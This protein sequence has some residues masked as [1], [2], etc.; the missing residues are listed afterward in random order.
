MLAPE[1]SGATDLDVSPDL[2]ELRLPVRIFISPVA[3]DGSFPGLQR[4]L[5]LTTVH[6]LGH[7]L[8]IFAHSP[9]PADIMYVDPVVEELSELDRETAEVLYHIPPN[10]EA[11]RPGGE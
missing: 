5:E 11:V 6:E 8:G 10:I 4:C 1:C 9:N 3:D 2:T 7:A